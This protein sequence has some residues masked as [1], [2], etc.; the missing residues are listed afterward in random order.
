MP[1]E[2]EEQSY[3]LLSLHENGE[4]TIM[5]FKRSIQACDDNDFHITVRPDQLLLFLFIKVCV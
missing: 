1:V 4:Q 2:D 5:T 3:T